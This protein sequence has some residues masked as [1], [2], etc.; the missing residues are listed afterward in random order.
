[1]LHSAQGGLFHL[2]FAAIRAISDL[3]F[4]G[5]PCRPCFP[6]ST[7]ELG[8]GALDA[9]LRLRVRDDAIGLDGIADY[10]GRRLALGQ[11]R[12]Q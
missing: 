11:P 5:H 10:I 9:L 1:M 6:P 7:A 2:L 3:L 8:S 12:Q 4:W